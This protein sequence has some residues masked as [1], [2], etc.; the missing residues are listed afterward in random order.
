M[1]QGGAVAIVGAGIAGLTT[2][3]CL[4][5]KGIASD[6]LEQT[7]VLSETGAGLQLSPNA[8]RILGALGLTPQLEQVWCEP[9]EI[10]LINGTTF[11]TIASVPAGSF[12]QHR[13]KAHYG[14]LH[15]ADLQKVLLAAVEA[16][17]LCRLHLG[18]RIDDG[19]RDAMARVLGKEPSLVIGADGV[20]S[21]VRNHI[22]GSGKARFSGNVAWRLTLS[23][24]N[25]PA[26]FDATTVSAFLGAGAH[27]VVYPL[28]RL[29]SFNVVAITGGHDPK[30]MPDRVLPPDKA[31]KQLLAA[32]SGWHPEIVDMLRNAPEPTIWPLYE[33]SEG[34][35]HHGGTVLIGDAAHAMMPFAAQGAA[36]AIEDAFEL[37]A[38]VAGGQSLAAFA[39]HR[40][41][42]VAHVRS[43]GAF[44]R[45]VYHARGPVRFGRDLVLSLRRPE[46]LAA[47]FD[48]LYGYEPRD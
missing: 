12:A 4:A 44:N 16:E 38:F 21:K 31:R 40:K 28:P 47:D 14:V 39:D 18:L 10:R 15:R 33:V 29:H 20:W 36:M 42:R 46:S 37:A 17:P 26:I 1:T 32:Y 9:A 3:L 2:A 30:D 23:Q 43:R 25:A 35:W 19:S 45:F 24:A 13:W 41:A 48:W 27:L 5:R 11:R 34:A 7:S 22:Q 6:I 8:T